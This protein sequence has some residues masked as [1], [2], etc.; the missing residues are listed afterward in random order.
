MKLDLIGTNC[1]EP[2]GIRLAIGFFITVY[3]Y[4]TLTN[5]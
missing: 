3:K 5:P 4:H 1:I 2:K